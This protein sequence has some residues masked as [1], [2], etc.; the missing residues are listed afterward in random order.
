PGP[1]LAF[2]NGKFSP[3]LSDLR[4]LP[5]GIRVSSLAEA[6]ETDSAFV[7]EHLGRAIQ[8]RQRGF[9]ALNEAW[10]TDG[11]VI[12][13]DA[14][15]EIQSPVHLLYYSSGAGASHPR[16]LLVV[17][18]HGKVSVVETY[19]GQAG[20]SYFVNAVT[21]AIVDE[22][23]HVDH[24]K[25]QRESVKAHHIASMHMHLAKTAD[26]ATHNITLG[27]A[28]TRNDINA[29]LDGEAIECTV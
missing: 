18:R 25:V 22:G 12:V 10:N 3:A 21:E 1:Q 17:G 5:P 7:Q 15:T 26:V 20:S 27:G 24:Y 6:L 8:F 14:D 4:P 13:V 28:L 29:T 23:G 19:A 9:T 16:T 2:V 11:A